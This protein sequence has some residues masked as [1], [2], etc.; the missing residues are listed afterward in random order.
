MS[1]FKVGF[2]RVNIDPMMNINISGYF[3]VRLADGVL[4]SLEAN[5]VAFE[6]DGKRGV[7]IALDLIGMKQWIFERIA[8]SI[9]EATGLKRD[10]I[11]ISCTHTHTGPSMPEEAGE[12][13]TLESEYLEFL[14]KRCTDGAYLALADLK[15][16]RMGWGIGKAERVAFIRRF[17]MKDGSI[18]TNPGAN[19]P[20]IV[21]P[22]GEVDERV[23]VLRFDREGGETVVLVNFGNHP[24]VVGGN[25]ISADWPGFLRRT[26]ERSIDNVRCL[27]FNGAEGDVNHVN[28]HPVG[29]DHNGMFNDFDD[30]MRGYDHARHMG[31]V[32]AGAVL[33]VFCK[34][35]Y[36]EVD[37]IN[38][39]IKAVKV[40]S[41]R[42]TAEELKLAHVYNDLHNA[43]KDDEIPYKGMMLTTVVAEAGRMVRL[44]NGPDSFEVNLSGFRIGPVT[45][46]GIAGEPFTG[47]GR[48][49][50]D[51][52]N[53]ELV[54]LCSLTNGDEGYYP[55]QEAY[56]E[57]GYEARSSPF[58]AGVAELFIEEGR[59]LLAEIK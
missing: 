23:N 17:F 30:V 28:V 43:G 11:F 53:E 10:E 42:A 6:C 16:A 52:G 36:V 46:I 41:N 4:D 32:M 21:A 12:K 25:K 54:L 31:N 27:F 45:L 13:G 33:S 7:M 35:K 40:P 5:T 19:N 37:S 49:I 18:K 29:G 38:S 55:M 20:D 22:V 47:I 24:D 44:E 2:S 26:V 57:G 9:G 39:A 56:D 58:K 15:S 50:K 34:V 48:G 3:K 51:G 1:N 14:V 8:Q 59:K